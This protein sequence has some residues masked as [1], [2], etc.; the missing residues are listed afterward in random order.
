MIKINYNFFLNNIQWM[1]NNNKTF[2]SMKF[3]F[4]FI[5]SKFIVF[6]NFH[7][8]QVHKTNQQ[9]Y[10]N[11]TNSNWNFRLA[12]LQRKKRAL[13]RSFEH[14]HKKNYDP[15][16][17]KFI[18]WKSFGC[19]NYKFDVIYH[20]PAPRHRSQA[21]VSKESNSGGIFHMMDK[22]DIR[23]DLKGGEAVSYFFCSARKFDNN[24]W[25]REKVFLS[26]PSLP[27]TTFRVTY[28]YNPYPVL[29]CAAHKRFC[30]VIQRRRRHES[31][32]YEWRL[33]VGE[34]RL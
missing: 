30:S 32:E 22:S 27:H 29:T 7:S 18:H 8:T 15:E 25:A 11:Y 12:I 13:R 5:Q 6:V 33:L 16:K 9:N 28:H 31:T 3:S 20:E 17:V 10:L 34:S 26:L 21:E 19:E 24:F 1:M 23:F 2:F 4:P 14:R